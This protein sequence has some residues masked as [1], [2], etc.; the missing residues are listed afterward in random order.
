MSLQYYKRITAGDFLTIGLWALDDNPWA[1][2]TDPLNTD[3]AGGIGIWALNEQWKSI[4]DAITDIHTGLALVEQAAEPSGAGEPLENHAG[5]WVKDSDDRL[6]FKDPAD[7]EN[8]IAYLSDIT[9]LD[10]QDSVLDKDLTAPPGAPSAGDR[11]IVAAGATGAWAGKDDDLTEWNGASWDFYT[12][13]EGW[14]CEVED[15]GIFYHFKTATAWGPLSASM[16]H[17]NMGGKQGGTTNEYYHLTASEHTE[18]S[19]WLPNVTLDADGDIHL[20]DNVSIYTG[21]GDDGKIFFDGFAINIE[22]EAISLLDNY[23]SPN[24]G[25]DL[26]ASGTVHVADFYAAVNP[27]T[28]FGIFRITTDTSTQDGQFLFNKD[29]FNM[30]FVINKL[31]SGIAFQYNAGTDDF[32]I[33]SDIHIPDNKK[34]LLGDADDVEFYWDG[35]YLTIYGNQTWESRSDE[36]AGRT[37]WK[38]GD[39]YYNELWAS[40]AGNYNTAALFRVEANDVSN[41]QAIVNNANRKDVDWIVRKNTAGDSIYYNAGDDKI[42]FYSEAIFNA[43]DGD[44]DFIIK[45]DVGNEGYRFDASYAGGY[46]QHIFK[47]AYFT[48]YG[49]TTA[50]QLWLN[51]SNNVMRFNQNN[52]STLDMIFEGGTDANLIYIDSGEDCVGIG[53]QPDISTVYILDVF[54]RSKFGAA[55]NYSEFE[56]DGTLVFNGNATVWDDIVIPAFALGVV[57]SIPDSI[58]FG[59][60]GNLKI[61]GFDGAAT[62]EML[63]GSFELPHG[64]KEGTDITV[65]VHWTPTNA[66]AGNVKWQFEYAWQNVDGTYGAPTTITVTDSTDSTAWKHLRADFA[67]ISGTGKTIG[68]VLVF[69]IFRDPADAA[70]TYASD[71]GLI[72]IGCHVELDTVG[73]RQITTK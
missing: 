9:G 72:D 67:A 19:A 37:W 73:S 3:D 60:S 7:V 21:T 63:Y 23:S 64:Y 58:N 1:D 29:N 35:G 66:N 16:Q 42:N 45:G 22:A 46:G 32:Y 56:A 26:W 24:K 30:D 8:K 28:N 43:G 50:T 13:N 27:P 2:L 69:R 55:V 36:K 25:I 51:F 52:I 41:F 68:S 61:R 17:N 33:N 71:A 12:P 31:T 11:Y 59:P 54:G 38:S 18:L 40:S 44:V 53:K 4:A 20:P 6:Y 65:H 47:G 15:E 57:A 49:G 5:L 62:S 70:D 34:I 10:W 39:N 14:V 48:V